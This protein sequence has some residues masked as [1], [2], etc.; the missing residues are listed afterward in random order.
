MNKQIQNRKTVHISEIEFASIQGDHFLVRLT[1]SA[2]RPQMTMVNMYLTKG[3]PGGGRGDLR[4]IQEAIR[5]LRG[6]YPGTMIVLDPDAALQPLKPLGKWTAG[7]QEQF[8]RAHLGLNWCKDC[9]VSEADLEQTWMLSEADKHWILANS[10]PMDEPTG[11]TDN[12][13]RHGTANGQAAT[14]NT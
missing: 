4:A 3:D 10:G 8:M 5:T 2:A 6:D 13:A 9:A 14:A 1:C 12:R 11:S 7:W